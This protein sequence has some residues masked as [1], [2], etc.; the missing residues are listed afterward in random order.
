M[1]HFMAL[2]IAAMAESGRKLVIG[3][4]HEHTFADGL[5]EPII[6]HFPDVRRVL[7]LSESSDLIF[8][9]EPSLA[10]RIWQLAEQRV[11]TCRP[12]DAWELA[13]IVRKEY[14]DLRQAMLVASLLEPR[15]LTSETFLPGQLVLDKEIVHKIDKKFTKL[16]LSVDLL[17]ICADRDG[18][19][20][21]RIMH[22]G[23]LHCLDLLGF[24]CI[25]P[26]SAHDH[27]AMIQEG[28]KWSL[29]V[30]RV[31]DLVRSACVG[32]TT[33]SKREKDFHFLVVPDETGA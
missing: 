2:C 20:L 30:E 22:P 26:E 28:Y 32:T 10:H 25:G 16:N 29:K 1:F 8:A 19:H 11:K 15:G 18:R 12:K 7:P 9:G 27:D 17:V 4:D 13:E 14:R 24:A 3:Y 6:H 23:T 21:F 5:D 31:R 33:D